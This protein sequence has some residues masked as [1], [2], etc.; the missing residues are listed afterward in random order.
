MT[1]FKKQSLIE[2]QRLEDFLVACWAF[3]GC[4]DKVTPAEMRAAGID[5]AQYD[6]WSH[7]K[8]WKL[9]KSPFFNVHPTVLEC[10]CNSSVSVD[11]AM[12]PA[13]IV[14]ELGAIEVRLP[15]KSK[16]PSF[17]VNLDERTWDDG[18]VCGCLL[19]S[20][21]EPVEQAVIYARHKFGQ[22]LQSTPN[23]FNELSEDESA[24]QDLLNRIA[25]GVLMLA[26]D[27]RYCEPI[28]LNRDKQKRLT[29]ED[30]K[31]AQNRAR[32]RGVYGFDIGKD[33][34]ISPHFRR[35][36]FA[37]RWTGEGRKVPKLVPVKG[38]VIN[39]RLLEEIP[40]GYDGDE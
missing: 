3:C 40:T 30:K 8:Q 16:L 14:H 2:K 24:V 23:R 35:P 28:L 6:F 33:V 31:K 29:E 9:A 27:S 5:Y 18:A 26:C 13:S 7:V 36:H 17:F 37:I 25:V 4:K 22:P 1:Q 32:N 10:L 15:E 34:E 19:V 21:W 11:P 39:K 12:I 20:Y 38:A